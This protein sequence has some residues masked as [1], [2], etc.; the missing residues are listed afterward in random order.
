M[1]NTLRDL[2]NKAKNRL[3]AISA[4]NTIS[5][6]NNFTMTKSYNES[7]LSARLQYA[8]VAN[9]NK[10][11]GDPLFAKIKKQLEKG[12]DNLNPIASLI[13]YKVYNQLSQTEKEKYIIKLTK[14]YATIKNYIIKD[15][16][17]SGV[18]SENQS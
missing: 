5:N 2:A 7:Y 17:D 12:E 11:E 1:L 6:E 4:Q 13:D 14:R 16:I 3:K 10:I 15:L 8:I 9:N 18:V